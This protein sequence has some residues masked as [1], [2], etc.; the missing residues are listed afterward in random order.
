MYKELVPKAILYPISLVQEAKNKRLKFFKRLYVNR[1]LKINEDVNIFYP[2]NMYPYNN[3]TMYGYRLSDKLIYDF[4][5][6]IILLLSNLNKRV[7]YKD[8]PRRCYLDSNPINKYVQDF[9]NI[10]AVGGSFGLGN[11]HRPSL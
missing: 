10:K 8:Y 5:K 4:E 6:K 7:I 11:T 2:S 1:M 9:K 3:I